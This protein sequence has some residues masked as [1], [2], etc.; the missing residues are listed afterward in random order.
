MI[1]KVDITNTFENS[2]GEIADL[3]HGVVT[4]KLSLANTK[5]NRLQYLLPAK[6]RTCS[7]SMYTGR[8]QDVHN[9]PMLHLHFKEKATEKSFCFNDNSKLLTLTSKHW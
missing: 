7:K 3:S 6:I 1:F 8:D 9:K 2:R 5:Q 4:K